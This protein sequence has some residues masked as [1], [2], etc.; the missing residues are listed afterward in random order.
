MRVLIILL[1]LVLSTPAQTDHS[2]TWAEFE[3]REQLMQY[4][5]NLWELFD[6]LYYAQG[7]LRVKVLE[8]ILEMQQKIND[9]IYTIVTLDQQQ[10]GK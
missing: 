2:Q 10:H 5:L 9:Q 3:A 8:E 4:Q 7:P 6:Q 1:F